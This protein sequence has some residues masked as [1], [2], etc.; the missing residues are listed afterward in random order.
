[1]LRRYKLLWALGILAVLLV[2]ARIALPSVVKDHVNRRL[3]ALESYDGHVADV[4]I[5]LWRGAY[6]VDDVVIVKTGAGGAT[7]FFAGDRV[8]FSVEWRSLLH[9]SLVSEAVFFSPD[10]NL[11]QAESK[12]LSQTGAG[13]N[14][15]DALEKLFPFRFNTVTVLDG[16]VT[17]RAPGIS[18]QDALQATNVDGEIS[19]IT[20]VVDSGQE[21]FAGF[22]ATA[23]MLETGTARVAGSTN[24]LAEQPTFDVNLTVKGVQLPKVNPWLREYIKADAESGEFELYTELAA[25]DGRFEGYAK[26]I[27]QNVNIVSSEEPV[28]NPL[29]RLWEGV[30]EFAAN[31]VENQ[32]EEQVAARIP[33]SGTIEN[34]EASIFETVVSVLR[35][36]FVSAFA[37]SL[38]GS[39]SIRDVEKNLA[40]IG[41]GREKAPED[42]D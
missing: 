1:M 7:P 33:F 14:W 23:E 38:E 5:A 9:G 31:I 22:A 26:P 11:V 30:V 17:F 29:R 20:N 40:E 16:K 6:R 25:A 27:L 8:D 24:P 4:D 37:R 2:G 36:A 12:E 15:A 19:N 41:D 42:E 28:E 32:E 13:V 18:T 3:A 39:I 35:N 34:P 10:I 21:T